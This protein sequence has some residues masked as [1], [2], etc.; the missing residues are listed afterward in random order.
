[1]I[2]IVGS[3]AWRPSEPA[4]PAGGACLLALAAA[5]RGARVELVGRVGDDRTGD[6]LV[7]A[8]A[9]A[10]VGHAA[11]LRDPARPTLLVS[12]AAAEDG[13]VDPVASAADP[14]A[15]ADHPAADPAASAPAVAPAAPLVAAPAAPLVAAPAA[16]AA[17]PRLEPA[18]VALGLS[19]LTSF[20]VLVVADDAPPEVV[21]ACVEGAAFAGAALVVL[22]PEDLAPPPDVPPSAT[23]LS[24]P[25]ADD[26]AFASMVGAY[27][28]GLEAGR[29]PAEAFRAAV[30]T[31]GWEP[32]APDDDPA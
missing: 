30:T 3:P 10:G 24:A 8:L 2:V 18:D 31:A 16:V 22:V 26:G 20:A 23:V 1:M 17:S 6:A 7:L 29:P 28:V 27:V 32:A 12:P 14:A 5:G 13:T 15:P 9:R 21:P 25:A 11:V 19:Y 4:G